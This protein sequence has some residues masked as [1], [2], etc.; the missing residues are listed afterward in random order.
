MRNTFDQIVGT[1]CGLGHIP[2]IPATWTSLAVA[3]LLWAL[4]HFAGAGLGVTLHAGEMDGPHQIA[5]A[6]ACAPSRIGHGW[7]II[8]DCTVVDGRI[9]ELGP[10]E[11]RLLHF[12]MTHPERVYS[13]SQLLDQVW[14]RNVYIEERTVDVH[15]R[16]LR[17]ALQPA[18]LDSYV[19]TVRGHGYRFLTGD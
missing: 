19:Q 16:R 8:D 9:V 17:K 7:R 1:V 15:I 14:G 3:L 5:S 13:R 10:T 4:A 12:F 2:V 6:L 18:G 11:F